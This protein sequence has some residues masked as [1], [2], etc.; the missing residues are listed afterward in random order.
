MGGY[1]RQGGQLDEASALVNQ[2]ILPVKYRLAQRGRRQRV[3]PELWGD[4]GYLRLGEDGNSRPQPSPPQLCCVIH[5]Y[6]SSSGLIV[7]A[8]CEWT[9]GRTTRKNPTEPLLGP[10][11]HCSS[12]GDCSVSMVLL[13]RREFI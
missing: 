9:D 4:C 13:G 8:R 3:Q 11:S 6:T 1:G 5:S 2:N 12:F 7:R 10:V